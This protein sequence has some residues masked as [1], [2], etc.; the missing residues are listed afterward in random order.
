MKKSRIVLL[1]AAS[2]AWPATSAAMGTGVAIFGYC[3]NFPAGPSI[4]SQAS[5]VQVS[6][7]ITEMQTSLAETLTQVG[8]SLAAEQKATSQTIA[9]EFGHQNQVLRNLAVEKGIAQAKTRA[10]ID[11]NPINQPENTCD[12][13]T[14]GAGIQVG[15]E[16]NRILN[17]DLSSRAFSH[18]I[19]YRRSA[20]ERKTLLAAPAGVFGPP[21]LFPLNST[22][23][24]QQLGEAATWTD[25]VT[26]P[27][28][29]P[30]LPAGAAVNPAAIRY[31]A[32]LRVNAARLSVPQETL[33]LIAA[34]HAPTINTG[35]WADDTWAAMTGSSS[36]SK[37]PG[38]VNGEISDAAL[39]RLQ[40][41]ARYANPNWYVDLAKENSVGVLREI[42]E[43]Q[44]VRAHIDY[45]RL[46]LAER[47]TAIEAQVASQKANEAARR[48]AG[49]AGAQEVS[50]AQ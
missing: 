25:A 22:M 6:M 1:I 39:V 2:V 48:A 9:S 49:G 47:R 29:L 41:N 7:Q 31:E 28:P 35:T 14:L 33:G 27:A 50:H 42:A 32:A 16:S 43:V 40:V 17:Q 12:A 20:D 45:L 23:S 11:E 26:A 46:R 18:D 21:A 10:A 36:S 30:A 24:P 37:P 15:G 8:R 3:K 13:P 5:L 34:L 44:A 38:E 19:Q 4:A